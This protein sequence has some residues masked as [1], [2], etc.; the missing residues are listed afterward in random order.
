MQDRDPIP[1]EEQVH[2]PPREA[3][4]E[5]LEEKE[6]VVLERGDVFAFPQVD[7]GGGP[8]APEELVEVR[9]P[10]SWRRQRSRRVRVRVRAWGWV[11]VG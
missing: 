7:G 8:V 5:H 2:V 10:G 11:W 6:D 3:P 4:R 1:A 9:S